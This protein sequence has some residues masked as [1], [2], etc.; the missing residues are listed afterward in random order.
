MSSLPP[1]LDFSTQHGRSATPERM[2]EA[3][4]YLLGLIK[5]VQ[6][7]VPDFQSAI[8]QMKAVGLDRVDEFLTPL[9][10]TAQTTVDAITALQASMDSDAFRAALLADAV[11]G[12]IAGS[13]NDPTQ[14]A[15]LIDDVIAEIATRQLYIET[16]AG[17]AGATLTA[18]TAAPSGGADNDLYVQTAP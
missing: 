5:T 18:G 16:G 7:V 4:D 8:D 15:S 1:E 9:L 3:M 12:A 17:S 2:N 6:A 13:F 11:A 10:A 14:R